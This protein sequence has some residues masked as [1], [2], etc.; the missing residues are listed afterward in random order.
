MNEFDLGLRCGHLMP[1]TGGEVTEYKNQFVGVRGAEIVKVCDWQ[2]SFRSQCSHFIDAQ[3]KAVMPGL[4]NAHTHLAMTLFRGFEDDVPFD[5]WLF[6]RVLPAERELVNEEFVR[7]GTS[8]AALESIRFG[9]TTVSDMY[10]YTQTIAEVI[11]TAGLR[12]F[13]GQAWSDYPLPEDPDLGRD[14]VKL[15]KNFNQKYAQHPRI[16]P[17]LS[18]HAP[19]SCTD[20][21][22]Q[23]VVDL[24]EKHDV[25]IHTHVSETENEV[26]ESIEKYQMTPVKRLQKLGVL[27]HAICAHSIHLNDEDIEIYKTEGAAMIYNP[28]SNLKLSSG[29]APIPKYFKA[30]VPVAM[31]TDGAAS[32]NNLSIIQ[33]INVGT[34]LQKLV[35]HD[36]TSMTAAHA[37]NA[38]T[39]G[40]ARA[41]RL[42]DRIGSIEEGKLADIIAVDLSS[43]HM[44]P[45][46]SVAGQ[47]AYS[48]NGLDVDTTICHGQVLMENKKIL[49]MN[50]EEVYAQVD[51]YQEKMQTELEKLRQ[52]G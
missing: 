30:N 17:A 12:A 4:I 24:A 42:A 26:K 46:Y 39:L 3:D 28:D 50:V 13:I 14:K 32:G 2:E 10:F 23:E 15:F 45:L 51:R 11:D 25:L 5:V 47:M 21:I 34:K 18:P 27:K 29:V 36:N 16:Y 43:P 19:Y 20:E 33:A 40:G 35:N 9:V 52:Q 48:A 38:A 37:L 22:W 31:G 41:L 1:M 49:S 44:K 8:L 7:V 6:Q